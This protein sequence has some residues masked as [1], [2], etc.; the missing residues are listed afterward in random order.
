MPVLDRM[1]KINANKY[2]QYQQIFNHNLGS[3]CP[4]HNNK[5]GWYKPYVTFEK[6]I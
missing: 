4:E 3:L 2:M 6:W 1:A 5:A